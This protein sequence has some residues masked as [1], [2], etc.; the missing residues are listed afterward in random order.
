M[1]SDIRFGW[2][3]EIENLYSLSTYQS[4][5][6][7]KLQTIPIL[8]FYWNIYYY[9][10]AE[11]VVFSLFVVDKFEIE[12]YLQSIFNTKKINA[13]RTQKPVAGKSLKQIRNL[14]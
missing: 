6:E 12:T 10:F 1:I 4:S 3:S 9:A 7:R 8:Y 2:F 5:V 14:Q 11:K 13:Q